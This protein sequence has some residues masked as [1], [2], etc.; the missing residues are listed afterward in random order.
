MKKILSIL[1]A[2]VAVVGCFTS[3]DEDEKKAMQLQGDW[4]GEFY[5]SYNY[6]VG[7]ETKLRTAYADLTCMKFVP[8]HMFGS[9]RGTGYELDIFN[10]G[11]IAYMYYEFDWKITDGVIHLTYFDNP[12]MNVDIYDYR[13]TNYRFQGYFGEHKYTID[14][15]SVSNYDWSPYSKQGYSLNSGEVVLDW[16]VDLRSEPETANVEDIEIV[17][18]ERK[19][20][21]TK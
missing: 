16:S 9:T 21:E 6:R 8:N 18:F 13:L 17:S 5:S 2:F 3:C 14:M 11:P 15:E 7:R 12:S 20:R 10:S 1:W 4:S 19:R